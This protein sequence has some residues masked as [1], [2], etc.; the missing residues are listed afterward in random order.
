MDMNTNYYR[1]VDVDY[2]PISIE[3]DTD[4]AALPPRMKRT[5]DLV[6][7]LNAM[8]PVWVNNKITLSKACTHLIESDLGFTYDDLPFVWEYLWEVYR[9]NFFPEKL[10]RFSS[11][12]LFD[13]EQN[14]TDFKSSHHPFEMLIPCKVELI[15]TRRLESYD[16]AWLDNVPTNCTF[17]EFAEYGKGYWSGAKTDSPIIEVLFSGVYK[18]SEL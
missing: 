5:I 12:F 17:E 13:E 15:E 7:A 16:M 2:E 6:P 1:L 14:L 8:L 4:V 11:V 18:L 3:I 10:S 9:K